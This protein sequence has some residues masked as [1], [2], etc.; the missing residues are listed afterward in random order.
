VVDDQALAEVTLHLRRQQA[1]E[2]VSA[3][4]RGVGDDD[5]DGALRIGLRQSGRREQRGTDASCPGPPGDLDHLCFLRTAQTLNRS[6]ISSSGS[7][8]SPGRSGTSIAP[9]TTGTVL[10]YAV[11][12]TSPNNRSSGA[13]RSFAAIACKVAR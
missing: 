9:S 8:P 2:H 4:A 12:P 13:A 3:A 1:R 7:A 5:F 11:N 10:A 6:I